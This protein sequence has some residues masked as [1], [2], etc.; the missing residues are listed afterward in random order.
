MALVV[1][2]AAA[3]FLSG[4]G[5]F[6]SLEALR[7]Q[8]LVLTALVAAHPYLS[9]AG[10]MG[11]YVAVVAFSLPGALIMS[12]TGGLLFGVWLGSAAA[13]AGASTGAVLMFLVARSAL[14][15][16]LRTRTRAGGMTHRIEAGVRRNAFSCI[17]ALRLIPAMPFC[18]V[19]L[20]A[21]FV[22][23][24]LKT[25]WWATVLGIAPATAVYAGVGASLGRM[26]DHGGHVEL[27]SLFQPHMFVPLFGLAGLSLLP[28]AYQAWRRRQSLVAVRA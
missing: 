15:D 14:G 21:G 22:K 3:L 9:L 5:R 7:E 11:L 24:P 20:A 27:Q 26:F 12:L 18:L 23:M 8:R 16:V 25:Y 19:N 17:L 13:V 2:A 6:L 1:L 4:A 10:Y 28:L